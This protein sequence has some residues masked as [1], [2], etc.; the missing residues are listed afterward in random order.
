MW[1]NPRSKPYSTLKKCTVQ[2]HLLEVYHWSTYG[3][4]RCREQCCPVASPLRRSS[5][6]MSNL[7][8]YQEFNTYWSLLV[9]SPQPPNSPNSPNRSFHFWALSPTTSSSRS[10]FLV[11]I[12]PNPLPFFSVFCIAKFSLTVYDLEILHQPQPQPDTSP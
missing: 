4:Q 8:S 10:H 3:V 7:P 12:C 9:P 2:T 6:S 1:V 5:L 11:P